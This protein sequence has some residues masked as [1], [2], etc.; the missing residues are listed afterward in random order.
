MCVKKANLT[1]FKVEFIYNI[2]IEKINNKT[3]P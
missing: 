1:I 2:D 3:F